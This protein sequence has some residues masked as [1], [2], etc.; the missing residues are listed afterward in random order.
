MV[1]PLLMALHPAIQGIIIVIM[2][3]IIYRAYIWITTDGSAALCAF[4]PYAAMNPGKCIKAGIKGI[5]KG[6]KAVVKGGKATVKFV[7]KHKID[8]KV[9][10]G[11]KVV[12][13]Q[14]TKAFKPKSTKKKFKKM[15]KSKKKRRW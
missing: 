6:A 8:K 2:I 13:K 11:G 10:K 5:K 14:V 7:K 1:L 9:A 4:A 3:V 15:F 12:G